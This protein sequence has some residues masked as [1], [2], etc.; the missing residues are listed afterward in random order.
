MKRNQ[1]A[2]K[3]KT[4]DGKDGEKDKDEEERGME[5]NPLFVPDRKPCMVW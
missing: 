3:P 4:K 2:N 1:V 5:E